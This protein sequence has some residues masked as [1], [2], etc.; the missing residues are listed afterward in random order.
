MDDIAYTILF[1]FLFIYF[2]FHFIY[3]AALHS[4][5]CAGILV[6][7]CYFSVSSQYNFCYKWLTEAQ[8]ITILSLR[9]ECTGL[10]VKRDTPCDAL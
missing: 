4:T 9:I 10:G 8:N 5:R 1:I 2:L 7:H 3:T 6:F